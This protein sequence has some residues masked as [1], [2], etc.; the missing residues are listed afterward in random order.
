[1]PKTSLST[2]ENPVGKS[3]QVL[4][5]TP[6]R[7]VHSSESDSGFCFDEQENLITEISQND[8]LCGRGGKINS[9]PGIMILFRNI[10]HDSN[11]LYC[12]TLLFL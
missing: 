8:V 10:F 2:F 7:R 5:P 9:H 3:I 12:S 1:M 4:N 6:L 11:I